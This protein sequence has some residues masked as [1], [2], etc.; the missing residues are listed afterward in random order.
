MPEALREAI[1]NLGERPRSAD[2][3]PVITRLC[4]E[5]WTTGRDLAAWLGVHPRNLRR[6][7][8]DPMAAAGLLERRE[9]PEGQK[10][11]REY[12]APANA[13]E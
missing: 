1:R 4:A 11:R 13:P 6:R 10:I 8:L 5:R 12:R 3:R 7:H 2:L 9:R